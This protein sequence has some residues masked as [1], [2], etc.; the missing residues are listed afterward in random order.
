MS[1]VP[2]LPYS[3]AAGD[4]IAAVPVMGNFT[5]IQTAVN[6]SAVPINGPATLNG[7]FTISG[8]L[9]VLGSLYGGGGTSIAVATSI[10]GLRAVSK[11]TNSYVWVAGYTTP[12]DGGGG[13]Y[14]YNS[15]DVISADN[16]GTIIVASD[17]GRWYLFS[18]DA[19]SIKQFGATGNGSTDDTSAI[20][21]ALNAVSSVWVP[22]GTFIY[23]SLT[24]NTGNKIT[25]TG[26]LKRQTTAGITT[27]EKY[28]ITASSV[29]NWSITGITLDGNKAGQSGAVGFK[30]SGI[31]VRGCSNVEISRNQFQNWHEDCIEITSATQSNPVNPYTPPA[32]PADAIYKVRII[33]NLFMDSGRNQNDGSGY[34]DSRCVQVGSTTAAVKIADNIVWNCL[35]GFQAAAYNRHLSITDNVGFVDSSTLN[36]AGQWIQVEQLSKGVAVVGNH[37]IG[38]QLGYNIE[39]AIGGTVSGNNCE[40]ALQCYNVFASSISGNLT[41]LGELSITGNRGKCR[42]TASG[43]FAMRVVKSSGNDAYNVTVT[44]NEF[45]SGEKGLQISGVTG[46]RASGNHVVGATTGYDITACVKFG[47]T[48]NDARDCAAEGFYFGASNNK[49]TASANQAAGCV[50]GCSVAAGQTDLRI[51]DNDWAGGNTTDFTIASFASN[52][53]SHDNNRY[54]T[55]SGT[56]R[57]LSGATPSVAYVGPTSFFNNG[58]VTTVTALSGGHIGEV[59]RFIA[60]NNNTTLQNGTNIF[61]RSHSNFP[62][63]TN[64]AISLTTSD[65]THWYE[66]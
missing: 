22:D 3:I 23:S 45:Q 58:G 2:S 11:L 55:E 59:Y 43:T 7:D 57:N 38:W 40:D 19:V 4:L 47:V 27:G 31:L 16:G 50:T 10:T 15:A 66:V 61:M 35:G 64:D 49:V 54:A 28:T 37:G 9:T 39:S 21:K 46:G 25:G 34:S 42:S 14:W 18:T 32:D 1:I 24:I 26:T 33:G 17:G 53:V 52:N 60:Q 63:Q 20:Q 36:F 51:Y 41:D 44:G 48:G 8:N 5:A 6:A 12:G 56:I 65:G 30:V 29:N 13:T 62:M